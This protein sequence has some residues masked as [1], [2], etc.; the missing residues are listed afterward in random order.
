[1][2]TPENLLVGYSALT[3][4]IVSAAFLFLWSRLRWQRLMSFGISFAAI[5][6]VLIYIVSGRY[7]GTHP[8]H[9]PLGTA[10]ALVGPAFLLAGCIDHVGKR[11]PWRLIAGAAIAL[12]IVTLVLFE[13]TGTRSIV[14]LPVVFGVMFVFCAILFWLH[15]KT[16][17]GRILSGLFLLRGI[18]MLPWPF[19]L[20]TPSMSVIL[21][22]AQVLV[23]ATGL[24]LIVAELLRAQSDLAGANTALHKQTIALQAANEKIGAE[25]QLAVSASNAKSNFLANMSHELR[26]PLNAI[27]GFSEIIAKSP[28]EQTA[29]RYMGYGA[30]IHQAATALHDF[31]AQVLELSRIEANRIDFNPETVDVEALVGKAV[32]AARLKTGSSPAEII[33]Y[34]DEGTGSI[35][36]DENLLKQALS[37]I[38][39]RA[40]RFTGGRGTVHVSAG[41]EAD[42]GVR[43]EVRDNGPS[44][45][46]N[47]I[48]DAFN[49]FNTTNAT[50]AHTGGGIDLSLPLAKRFVEVHGG[51]ISINNNAET[52][53]VVAIDLPRRLLRH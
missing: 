8:L 48:A 31:V 9:H 18:I 43:I 44:L 1:M 22:A 38:L 11:V 4:L 40:L 21:V 53:S 6:L 3:N 32:S 14:F 16:L 5:S 23:L 20:F 26:T 24:A 36:G 42:D 39:I 13:T 41:P 30:D 17:G 47:E 34:F 33:R 12:W 25:R 10:A 7:M 50:V 46:D 51:E 15:Q 52:G 2:I 37:G 35:E 49:A 45:T 27:M 19:V 28:A 29:S